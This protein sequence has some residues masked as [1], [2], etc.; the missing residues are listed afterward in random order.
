MTSVAIKDGG[1]T[2]G[3]EK[4]TVTA[5]PYYTWCN[6]GSNEMQVWLPTYVK[7]VRV[8]SK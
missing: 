6:R 1:T 3:T 2:I 5:I 4:K 8:N 7:S